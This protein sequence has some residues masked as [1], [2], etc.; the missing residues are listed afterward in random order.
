MKNRNIGH[1]PA[2]KNELLISAIIK[3]WLA[4][5]ALVAILASFGGEWVGKGQTLPP[6]TLPMERAE[7]LVY[8]PIVEV[9]YGI[10]K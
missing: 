5:V 3:R 2:Y 4:I 7:Y 1:K 6:G 9:D 8:L 10:A